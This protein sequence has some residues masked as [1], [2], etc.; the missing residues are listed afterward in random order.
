MIPPGDNNKTY[1]V[2]VDISLFDN[3][4]VDALEAKRNAQVRDNDADPLIESLSDST[5][6]NAGKK[7]E[8]IRLAGMFLADM[9]DN[10][11]KTSLTLQISIHTQQQM[12]GQTSYKIEQCLLTLKNIKTHY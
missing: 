9:R 8:L 10:L 11:L 1:T 7:Q 2:P 4:T 6:I 12:S 3:M 5:H